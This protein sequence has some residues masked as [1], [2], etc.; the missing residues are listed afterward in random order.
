MTLASTRILV[1]TS[2]IIDHLRGNIAA[3]TW[4]KT[5]DGLAPIVSP[6]TLHELRRGIVPGS[7]WESQ[8][9]LLMPPDSILCPPPSLAEWVEAADIIRRHFGKVRSKADLATLAHDTLICLAAREAKA[10]LWSRDKGF[11]LICDA[12]GV[13]LL[14][15]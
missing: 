9:H 5:L 4:S 7:R 8:I 2:V 13:P 1:D 3:D 12:I 14:D 15:F 6:V 10:N 11:R